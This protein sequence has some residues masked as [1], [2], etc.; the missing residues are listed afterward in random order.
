[1]ILAQKHAIVIAL[2][3]LVRLLQTKP[4]A[5]ME[6]RLVMMVAVVLVADVAFLVLTK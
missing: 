1:M 5:L 4:D 6:L 2:Q 3:N